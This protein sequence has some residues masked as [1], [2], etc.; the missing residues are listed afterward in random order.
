MEIIT[1]NKANMSKRDV[2][3]LT[4]G[5]T[6]SMKD[7]EDGAEIN[8]GIWAL[9]T[10]VNSKGDEVEILAVKDVSG[11]VFSTNSPTFKNEFLFI[12]ALMNDEQYGIRV[13]KRESKA[14][15]TFITCELV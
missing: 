11:N 15:R 14:G 9:Y 13:I 3:A 8:P 12:A 6:I 2:Y 7:V 4:R 10:D 5:Q 1:T